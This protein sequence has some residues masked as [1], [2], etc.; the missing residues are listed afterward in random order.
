LRAR[1]NLKLFFAFALLIAGMLGF[2]LLQK[3]DP[4]SFDLR[5]GGRLDIVAVSVSTNHVAHFGNLPQKALFKIAGGRLSA[6]WVGYQMTTTAQDMRNGNLGI[7]VQHRL[8]QG[9]LLAMNNVH[10]Y[11]IKPVTQP[12]PSHPMFLSSG[13]GEFGLWELN[14]WTTNS[15]NFLVENSRGELI[16]KFKILRDSGDH[17]DRFYIV[18]ED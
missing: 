12:H 2:V 1:P 9:E 13:A 15:A 18:R 4:L 10:N 16:G 14:Y 17:G 7:F 8:P 3:R 11:K 5:D 6:K